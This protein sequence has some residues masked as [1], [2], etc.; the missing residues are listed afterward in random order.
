MAN[1]TGKAIGF[2]NVAG[3]TT[4]NEVGIPG[5]GDNE[6]TNAFKITLQQAEAI[7]A[8]VISNL[9]ELDLSTFNLVG[10]GLTTINGTLTIGASAGTG[11]TTVGFKPNAGSSVDLQTT[12]KI[13]NSGNFSVHD[14]VI[15]TN[16]N[17]GDYIQTASANFSNPNS[18]NVF[19]NFKSNLGILITLTNHVYLTDYQSNVTDLQGSFTGTLHLTL[20]IGSTAAGTVTFG[21][22]CTFD[23][24]M[25]V[26]FDILDGAT[27]TTNNNTHGTVGQVVTPAR[28]QCVMPAMDFR[29]AF[30]IPTTSTGLTCYIGPGDLRAKDLAFSAFVPT[31]TFDCSKYNPDMY[32]YRSARWSNVADSNY[33]RG[34]GIIYLV[35]IAG[36][37]DPRGKT[38]E[39]VNVNASGVAKTCTSTFVSRK[40]TMVAGILELLNGNTTT[41]TDFDAT[42]GSLTSSVAGSQA[43]LIVTNNDTAILTGIAVKDIDAS[44]G[45]IVV[46]NGTDGGN[47]ID[48][49]FIEDENYC[50]ARMGI[51]MGLSLS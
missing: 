14:S 33:I 49:Y 42:G 11:L 7:I 17:R 40:L 26:N 4:W 44:G 12:S 39:E 31:G 51:H 15:W 10:T 34:T 47:N 16:N 46:H 27:I 2:W 5:A 50:M 41:A 48:V 9:G 6:T 19:Y 8:N 28:D 35:G 1:Y 20:F 30:V 23:N 25:Y 21:A 13:N 32:I 22:G 18:G 45:P 43:A 29:N 3:Q 24:A 38:I 36:D 37:F